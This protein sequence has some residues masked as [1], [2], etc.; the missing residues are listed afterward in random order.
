MLHDQEGVE[1]E[2]L[3]EGALGAVNGFPIGGAE[4][5]SEC[6]AYLEEQVVGK[7][8]RECARH[9]R[10]ML[11]LVEAGFDVF[12]VDDDVNVGV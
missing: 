7:Y 9:I 8:V 1:K 5:G 12:G 2:P 11:D 10:V 4:V 3:G 6:E